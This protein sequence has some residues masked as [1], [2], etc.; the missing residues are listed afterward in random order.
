MNLTINEINALYG[1]LPPQAIEIEEAILGALILEENALIEN[2]INP[3][4]FY[5]DENQKICEAIKQL[6]TDGKKIDLV[7]VTRKLMDK[8]IL[9]LVGGPAYI[10]SL[11]GKVASSAHIKQHI[12]ILYDM[13]TRRKIIQISSFC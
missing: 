12:R 11:V 4:W 6:N 9:D 2:N 8:G 10:T 7:M 3:E 1:K 5:K 13:W